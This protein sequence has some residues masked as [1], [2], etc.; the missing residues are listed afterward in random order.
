MTDDI[1]DNNAAADCKGGYVLCRSQQ[2]APAK[3]R[4]KPKSLR[5]PYCAA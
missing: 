2:A 3:G 4:P 1:N 5:F